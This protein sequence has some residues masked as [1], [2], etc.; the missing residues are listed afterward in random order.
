VKRVD[1][2]KAKTVKGV[3]QI[4][5]LDDAVA[6]VADQMGAAK[7]GLAALMI[8]WDDGPNAKLNTK[9]VVAELEKQR[10]NQGRLR[11]TWGAVDKAPASAV[12]KVEATYQVPFLAHI[13]RQADLRRQLW[14]V[15]NQ[16]RTAARRSV[17]SFF[18]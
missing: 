15:S 1:D 13:G 3:R 4:V 18:R 9:D 14:Q 17:L 6:V 16:S 7:K 10:S 8:E 5:R 11:R 12:T 2:A